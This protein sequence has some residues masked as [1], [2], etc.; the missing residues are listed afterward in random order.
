MN[1]LETLESGGYRDVGLTRLRLSCPL[2]AFPPEI[3]QLGDTLEELDLSDTGL[4]ELP[5][6]LGSALPKLKSIRLDRCRFAVFPAALAACP[7]LETAVLRSNHMSR[8]PED[9]LPRT[10]RC[11]VLTDNRLARLPRSISRCRRL[12]ACRL[13]ANE[14]RSLPRALARCAELTELRLSGNRLRALPRWLFALPK[15][16]FLSFASNPC[17]SPVANGHPP[18][19]KGLSGIPWAE[20]EVQPPPPS[21]SLSSSSSSTLTTTATTTITYQGLWRQSPHYAEEVAVTL[22]RGGRGARDEG[23]PADE[24]AAWLAAGAHEALTTV[25][26][27]VE[28]HPDEESDAL[29][30]QGCLVTQAVPEGYARLGRPPA[31]SPSLSLSSSSSSAGQD[32]PAPL[33]GPAGGLP[34]QVVLELLTPLAGALAHL[35]ARRICHGALAPHNVLASVEDR[36]ALLD[37]F[38]AATVYAGLGRG[39]AEAGSGEAEPE[40]SDEEEEEEEEEEDPSE[41]PDGVGGLVERVEV[42]AFGRLMERLLGG[43]EP[44]GPTTAAAQEARGEVEKGLWRLRDMCVRERASQ[45]PGFDV[46]ATA[47]EEM[48]GWR[49]MMRIPDLAPR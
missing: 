9:A 43:G 39:A 32:A 22:F 1:S 23:C 8:I 47:L 20:L 37:G 34:P 35:H 7:A 15:L 29:R 45:R 12:A 19:P 6:D 4:S 28:G 27:W 26:G 36:H 10:L 17:V 49:G 31:S 33:A 11:L 38:A 5:A 16:A 25:L 40:Q 30:H 44:P 18:K 48:M 46:V 13:A 24:L 21:P 14:L 42:L 3:L 2:G 41:L